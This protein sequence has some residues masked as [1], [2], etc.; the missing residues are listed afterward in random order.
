[1]LVVL[2][3]SCSAMATVVVSVVAVVGY[4]SSRYWWVVWFDCIIAARRV[5]VHCVEGLGW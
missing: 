3:I 2:K 1:M 5:L 4:K